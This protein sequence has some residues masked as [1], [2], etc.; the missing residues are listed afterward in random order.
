MLCFHENQMRR[1]CCNYYKDPFEFQIAD[2]L[3]L[4]RRGRR[5]DRL[6]RGHND[7]RNVLVAG[8]TENSDDLT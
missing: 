1:L 8:E 5:P 6:T 3:R 4:G 2:F 7:P